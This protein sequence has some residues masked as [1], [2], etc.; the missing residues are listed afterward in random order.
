MA[1]RILILSHD[2]GPDYLSDLIY[3]CMWDLASTQ[4]D[5]VHSNVKPAYLYNDF[6]A[7]KRLYG[8]GFTVYR[9]LNRL[10]D[11]ILL[12]NEETAVDN[13][14]KGF[15]D[16]IVWPSIQRFD[17]HV[18]RVLGSNSSRVVCCDG[19]DNQFLHQVA[20]TGC[21]YFKRELDGRY[22][23]NPSL[24]VKPIGFCLPNSS[25]GNVPR[26]C[27]VD[28]IVSMKNKFLAVC[29][30]RNPRSYIYTDEIEYYKGYQESFFGITT[31]KGG[32]DCMRHYEIIFNAC[33]PVFLD[34]DSKPASILCRWPSDLQRRANQLYLSMSSSTSWSSTELVD[35]GNLLTLFLSY[36]HKELI[37]SRLGPVL[38]NG[39]RQS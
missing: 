38:I 3:H 25:L 12:V 30:P 29:D 7:E 32:W 5:I 36:A 17:S 4:K 39:D 26:L 20:S 34:Y 27:E 37:S 1:R 21:L 13:A 16:Y 18:Y 19:E 15:Y 31:Q 10:G 9:K 11:S 28:N 2:N 14:I 24:R 6:A 8:R 22:Q 23:A 35:Y 33:L